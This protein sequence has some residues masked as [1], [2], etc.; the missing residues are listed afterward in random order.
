MYVCNCKSI[1]SLI[2]YVCMR[3]YMDLHTSLPCIVQDIDY[4]FINTIATAL[5]NMDFRTLVSD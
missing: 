3:T 2:A 4:E 1:T 5:W